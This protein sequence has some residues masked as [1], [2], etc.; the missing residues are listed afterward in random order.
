MMLALRWTHPEVAAVLMEQDKMFLF[1]KE[2]VR[3]WKLEQAAR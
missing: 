2:R 1:W 3:G